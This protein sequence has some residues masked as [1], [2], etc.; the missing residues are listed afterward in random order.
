MTAREEKTRE[1][2]ASLMVP[3]STWEALPAEVRD[4][5]AGRIPTQVR[6]I[7]RALGGARRTR[8]I[9]DATQR[10]V[11]RIAADVIRDSEMPAEDPLGSVTPTE[12]DN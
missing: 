1:T 8:R 12:S 10:R 7:R 2:L 6:A 5:V 11:E 4:E 3:S 9:D